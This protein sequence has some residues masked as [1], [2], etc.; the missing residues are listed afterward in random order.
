[1]ARHADF[2]IILRSREEGLFDLTILFDAPGDIEDY[3]YFS[4][5]DDPVRIDMDRLDELREDDRAYGVELGR[6]LFGH[7]PASYLDRALRL[8]AQMPVHVRLIVDD[9]TPL[10]YRAIRWETLRHPVSEVRVATNENIR[11]SRYLSNPDGTPP[12][13]LELHHHL[14]AL[15]VVANPAGI[16]G[17]A[18]GLHR[19]SSADVTGEIER[20][21][22]ALDNMS[23]RVLGGN[24]GPATVDNLV[25]ALREREVNLLYLVC[26]GTLDQ[27]GPALF[28]EN[29]RGNVD[30]VDGTYLA[31]RVRDLTRRVR[32]WRCWSP[33][34]PRGRS[35]PTRPRRGPSRRGR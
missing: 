32:P 8:A 9:E 11:F 31:D 5:R 3:Q 2:E 33:A 35:C 30:R 22:K 7:G 17:H 15:V 21:R 18:D 13:P 6:L 28:L 4:D 14:S 29:E 10:R 23:V 24:G 1:M 12:S 19:L 27:D 16:E 25:G 34:S 26:H 20:A